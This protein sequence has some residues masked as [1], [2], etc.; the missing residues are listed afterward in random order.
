MVGAAIPAESAAKWQGRRRRTRWGSFAAGAAVAACCGCARPCRG[1]VAGRSSAAAPRPCGGATPRPP[2]AAA[3][4]TPAPSPQEPA[5]VEL[6][7]CGAAVREAP[8]GSADWT[9]ANPSAAA[10]ELLYLFPPVAQNSSCLDRLSRRLP[11]SSIVGRKS[12]QRQPRFGVSRGGSEGVCKRLHSIEYRR[13]RCD[14]V[15]CGRP[16]IRLSA[17]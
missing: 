17:G 8:C 9:R 14:D 2:S 5:A 15:A 16:T 3:A 13:S 11:R 6:G 4:A 10:E 1:C 7:R 12:R